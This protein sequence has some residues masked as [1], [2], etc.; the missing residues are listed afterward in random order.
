MAE[1]QVGSVLQNTPVDNGPFRDVCRL[2]K[3]RLGRWRT[4][5]DE[6][7]VALNS[8]HCQVPISYMP[9]HLRCHGAHTTKSLVINAPR[10]ATVSR[11]QVRNDDNVREKRRC[12]IWVGLDVHTCVRREQPDPLQYGGLVSA[13][14]S[15][16]HRHRHRRTGRRRQRPQLDI[17]PLPYFGFHL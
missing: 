11:L 4:L 14:W 17:G 6:G 12:L 16:G 3:G 5:A 2:L 1:L 10:K 8:A 7:H 13:L 15:V 9:W